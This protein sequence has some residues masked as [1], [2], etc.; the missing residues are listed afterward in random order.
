MKNFY[1]HSNRGRDSAEIYNNA[2][3]VEYKS[4]IAKFIREEVSNL[5]NDSAE[6]LRGFLEKVIDCVLEQTLKQ[7]QKIGLE[8]LK[9]C[10]QKI[11]QVLN[12]DLK[13][14]ELMQIE[15][16]FERK[17]NCMIYLSC[18]KCGEMVLREE[19]FC[20]NCGDKNK[21]F[22]PAAFEKDYGTTLEAQKEKIG[23]NTTHTEMFKHNFCDL[24]G[25]K[26]V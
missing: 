24:C 4:E 8:I 19:V 23:C 6:E 9:F 2:K 14:V 22:N 10:K 3:E 13:P 11:A 12:R 16:Y 7:K 20:S 5:K 26:L 18:K 17:F 25:K 21:K 15:D 1:R